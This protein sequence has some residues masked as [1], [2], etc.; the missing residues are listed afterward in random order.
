MPFLAAAV[1]IVGLLCLLD[2]LLT[3]GV[4]RR[5]R[6]HTEQLGQL[7]A[8]GGDSGSLPIGA[9]VPQ[10][11]AGSID[12]EPIGL[13]AADGTVVGFFSTTCEP[14]KQL[15]PEFIDYAANLPG[16][17]S[18]V[19]AV[20]VGEDGDGAATAASLSSVA[21]VVVEHH[22]GTVATAFRTST[23]PTLYVVA[24]DRQVMVSGHTMD[25]LRSPATAGAIG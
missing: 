20:V 15:L 22:S 24:P 23:F 18:R 7:S 10:F 3:V 2:L 17:R 4:I 25:V 11:E 12:G 5:L 6:E 8:A 9:H 21:Q 16:G 1:V 19:L 14:C 13:D